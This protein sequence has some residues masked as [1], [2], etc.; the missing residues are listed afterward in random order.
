M[1]SILKAVMDEGKVQFMESLTLSAPYMVRVAIPD[2]NIRRGPGTGYAKTGRYTGIGNFTIVE[3]ADG[4]GA[5]KWGLLKAY[6][7][8]RDGWISLDHTVRM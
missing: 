1:L 2:L 3:E 4:K 8:K 5:S 6:Q 7:D